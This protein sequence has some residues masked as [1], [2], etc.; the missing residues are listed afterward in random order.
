[1]AGAYYFLTYFPA[2]N[3][4]G[5]RHGASVTFWDIPNTSETWPMVIHLFL[6]VVPFLFHNV[7]FINTHLLKS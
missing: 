5:P 3:C 2:A 6:E 4:L 7:L 1:M